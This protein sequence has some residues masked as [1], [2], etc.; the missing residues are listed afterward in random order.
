MN[1]ASAISEGAEEGRGGEEGEEDALLQAMAKPLFSRRQTQKAQGL[2]ESIIIGSLVCG[3]GHW[4][5]VGE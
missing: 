2:W 4:V 3:G 5:L 1:Y